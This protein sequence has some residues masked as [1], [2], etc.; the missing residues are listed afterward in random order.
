MLF[1]HDPERTDDS[2]SRQLALCQEM[3]AERNGKVEVIAAAEGM[4][5]DI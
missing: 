1:H 2:L 3:V 5:L 4:E